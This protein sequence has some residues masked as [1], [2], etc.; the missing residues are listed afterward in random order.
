[1]ARNKPITVSAQIRKG[2]LYLDDRSA[3]EA[4][5]LEQ[6]DGPVAVRVWRPHSR[7]SDRY[8]FGVVLAL[9]SEATGYTIAEA[10]AAMKAECNPKIETR[11]DRDGVV[12]DTRVLAGST[13][14][15]ADQEM[16]EYIER[17]RQFAAERLGVSIPDPDPM[18]VSGD[19]ESPTLPRSA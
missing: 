4:D 19:R 10:H 15:L 12:I 5:V 11:V 18:M 17:V 9:I 14:E 8:Y 16:S 6:P 3:F 7:R 1:V 13:T 2:K